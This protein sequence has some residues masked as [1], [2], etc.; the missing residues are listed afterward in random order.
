MKYLKEFFENFTK[1][2]A[3][4]T[5]VIIIYSYLNVTSFYFF[6][7]VN[8]SDYIDI[9]EIVPASIRNLSHVLLLMIIPFW[10]VNY[11]L[12]LYNK[13]SDNLT[14]KENVI[15]YLRIIRYSSMIPCFLYLIF[16][17]LLRSEKIYSVKTVFLSFCIDEFLLIFLGI[18]LTQTIFDYSF[19]TFKKKF[20]R[21]R[22]M[23]TLLIMLG[24]AFFELVRVNNYN[25]DQIILRNEMHVQISFYEGKTIT[26]NDTIAYIGKTKEYYFFLQSK[27][28]GNYYL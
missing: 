7:N 4:V 18:T 8:I 1:I 11:I 14:T 2:I 9:T 20:K 23:I 16:K 17:D 10:I 24:L 3:G 26:T 6:F 5:L 28:K 22:L 15:S 27:K 21:P 13:R 12:F 25:K 19:D